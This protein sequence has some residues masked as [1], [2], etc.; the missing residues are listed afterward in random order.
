MNAR[1]TLKEAKR[2]VIKFG[3]NVVT[4]ESGDIAIGRI[5]TIIEDI[6]E[7]H[8]Q[9]KEILIVSSGAVGMGRKTINMDSKTKT[10]PLMQACAAIGQAR[11]MY[12]YEEGFD[13]L[14]ISIAQVLLTEEDFTD[15]KRYLNLRSTLNT[16]LEYKIIP[17]INQNDVV[18][19]SELEPIAASEDRKVNFGDNDKLSALVM[20]KLDADLLILLTDVDGLYNCNP[21]INSEAEIIQ[22]VEKITPEL[23][24]LCDDCNLNR[25]RGGMKSKLEAVKVAVNSGGKAIIANGKTLN[26]IKDIF[27]EKPLGTIFLPVKHL[28][29]KK[30][31]I[32]YATTVNG[33]LIVNDGAKN[34][35]INKNASLLPAGVVSIKSTFSV[36]DVVSIIDEKGNEFARGITN[37]S[38]ED[39]HKLIGFHSDKIE[40]VLSYKKYDTIISRDNIVILDK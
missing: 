39:S 33:G 5:Y 16:L 38:S 4:K 24:N 8:S 20:S 35:V 26:I 7:L 14:S 18:S 28:S 25:S 10:L 36:G 15:R 11:L 32:A 29:S 9:G 17:I 6:A 13:K 12:L 22:H 3:T 1:K 37:Y 2:I 27:D 19:T 40:Q 23:E 30:R 21:K 31:W 34:A